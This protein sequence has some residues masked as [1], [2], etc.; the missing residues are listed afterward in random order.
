MMPDG[1]LTAATRGM[2]GAMPG[3]VQPGQPGAGQPGTRQPQTP[4]FPTSQQAPRQGPPTLAPPSGWQS[5]ATQYPAP[6]WQQPGGAPATPWPQSGT[7]SVQTPV[8]YTPGRRRPMKT[9]VPAAVQAA[10]GMMW[11]GLAATVCSL[12]FSGLVLGRYN[13][14]AKHDVMLLNREHAHAMAGHLS[15]AILAELIGIVAWIWLATASRRGHGW[16][17]IAGTVLAG[18]YSI[19]ALTVLLATH[20]D[21][22][23]KVFTLIVWAVALAA[24]F[25]LWSRQAREFFAA[26]RH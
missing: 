19:I 8:P 23:A 26:W 14:D 10:V 16:T 6:S 7:P 11:T 15:L 5:P 25:L 12:I 24:V 18:L 2:P 9:E 21:P 3:T 20:N 1:Y 4:G 17:S 22:A 13:Y